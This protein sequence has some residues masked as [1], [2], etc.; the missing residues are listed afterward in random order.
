MAMVA[1]SISPSGVGSSVSQYVAA[2]VGV[3]DEYPEL[4]YELGP[5]FTTIEGDLDVVMAAIRE[6]QEA[7]FAQG[8]DRVNTVIKVDDRRDKPLTRE[9]K[10]QAV[11]GRLKSR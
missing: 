1:V 8:V 3:L 5:M 4:S 2:A 7:V 11:K 6:M 10:I 9:G